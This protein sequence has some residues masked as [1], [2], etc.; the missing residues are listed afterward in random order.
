MVVTHHAPSVQET[1][2][3]EHLKNPWTSAFASNLLSDGGAWKSVKY[4][5][6]GH[7]HYSVEFEK[8]GLTVV[9]NQR[10]YVLPG[11]DGD[12]GFDASKTINIAIQ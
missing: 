2:R 3:P 4:W 12:G 8:A 9:S 11:R 1:S 7:T 6:Y 10:G 5:V